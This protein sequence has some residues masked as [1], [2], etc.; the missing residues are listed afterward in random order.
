MMILILERQVN[1]GGVNEIYLIIILLDIFYGS[2]QTDLYLGSM[3]NG[4][5]CITAAGKG[6]PPDDIPRLCLVWVL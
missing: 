6:P 1:R 5:L 2:L 4:Q 3:K